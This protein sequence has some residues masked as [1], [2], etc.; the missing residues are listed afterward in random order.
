MMRNLF[1]VLLVY[2][3]LIIGIR[4]MGKRQIGELQPTELVVTI[5]LSN[6]ATLPMEIPDQPLWVN[7]VPMLELIAL[8]V[9]MSFGVLKYRALRHLLSGR[10]QVII[11]DG[12]VDQ[13]VMRKLRFTLDDLMTALRGDGIFDIGTVQLAIVETNGTVSAY[14]K[15]EDRPVTCK[16]AGIQGD[17]TAPPEVLV[18]D[19]CLSTD[20]LRAAGYTPDDLTDM[21]RARGLRQEEVF[22]L[23]ADTNGMRTIVEKKRK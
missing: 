11:R 10:P 6:L 17:E 22:L 16:D 4:L 2:P 21:L 1:H 18:S 20:G 3:I 15:A 5:L 12:E 14:Q 7:I 8:E 19:G 13:D 23:T 9:M